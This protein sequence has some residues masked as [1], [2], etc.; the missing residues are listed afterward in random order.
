MTLTRRQALTG[1]RGSAIAGVALFLAGT[2]TLTTIATTAFNAAE[3]AK[4]AASYDT[5]ALAVESRAQLYAADLDASLSDPRVPNASRTCA[6]AGAVCTTVITDTLATDSTHRTLRIQADDVDNRLTMTRDV[7]L[8]AVAAT[9]IT[10][11][12]ATGRPT[13]ASVDEG[14]IFTIWGVAPGTTSKVTAE[15]MSGP[16]AGTTWVTASS[17]NGV[18][19][20]G[21]AWV[22]GNNTACQAGTGSTT[23]API[24]PTPL[25]TPTNIRQTIAT[26]D[27]AFLLDAGGTAW[28]YGANSSGQ[29]GLGTTTNACTPTAIP[30]YRFLTIASANGSSFGI[31]LDHKL[32]AWGAGTNGQLGDGAK[33]N[34][35][36]PTQIA[37][38]A[39]FTAVTTNGASTWAL[40]DRGRLWSWGK[41]TTGQLAN[42]TTTDVA[43]ATQ[44][45]ATTTFTQLSAGSANIYAIDTTGQ[46][47]AAG[48]N[49]VGAVGDSTT[50]NRSALVKIATG[51]IM[52]AV[53]GGNARG[54]AIDTTGSVWAWG[55]ASNGRLGVGYDARTIL[56]PTALP[57]TTKYRSIATSVDTN[58]LAAID[59]DGNLWAIGTVG[60]GLWN[61][62][63]D[64]DP[65][66][67]T[68][69]PRP[70]GFTAP[71]WK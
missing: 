1:R 33:Q 6:A 21:R 16:K 25:S 52:V 4:R 51:T 7:Q 15:Q 56:T 69:M 27:V 26:A 61:A 42:G 67:A 63:L 18:D 68:R 54:F 19:S 49:T 20:A 38:N 3:Q 37:T 36:R 22:Y 45:T 14:R 64:D 34:Y 47:W 9:H 58:F 28:A 39:R 24:A 30:N 60:S 46:L 31:T 62:G 10:S 32:Y 43:Q 29:L 41:N 40:D 17:R 2:L 35:T 66:S 13:W 11:L 53:A 8:E 70:D 5:L 71:T 65:N 12:S 44:L 57:G 48:Q 59:T 23:T 50:T 55:D